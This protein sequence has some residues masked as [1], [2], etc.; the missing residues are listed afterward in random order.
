MLPP[1]LFSWH[2]ISASEVTS[3][4]NRHSEIPQGS[5]HLVSRHKISTGWRLNSLPDGRTG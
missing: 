3:V 5:A 2:A 4:G 1:E